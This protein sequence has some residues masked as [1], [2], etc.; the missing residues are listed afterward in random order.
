MHHLWTAYNAYCDVIMYCLG[1]DG[2][3]K[4]TCNMYVTFLIFIALLLNKVTLKKV[5]VEFGSWSKVQSIL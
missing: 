2:K 1:N 4:D 5:C 3:E